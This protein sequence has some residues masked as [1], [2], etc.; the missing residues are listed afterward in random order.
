M[1]THIHSTACNP[2]WL[3]CTINIP[4]IFAYECHYKNRHCY[5]VFMYNEIF[6]ATTHT[7][8]HSINVTGNVMV[9]LTWAYWK[10]NYNWTC[11]LLL[12][13]WLQFWVYTYKFNT[14]WWSTQLFY[15]HHP[16]CENRTKGM[17]T[18]IWNKCRKQRSNFII[19]NNKFDSQPILLN[20]NINNTSSDSCSGNLIPFQHSVTTRL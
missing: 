18:C 11:I 19:N 8:S 7:H 9:H 15:H 3:L 16:Q 17:R 5:Y 1:T 10:V 14:L 12:C 4:Q 6:L 13:W 20:F 2:F